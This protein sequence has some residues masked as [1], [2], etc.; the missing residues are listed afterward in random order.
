VADPVLRTEHLVLHPLTC[1]LAR[2]VLDGAG[3]HALA[4]GFPGPDDRSLLD[5]LVLAGAGDDRL[6]ARRP[7]TGSRRH[8]G[9]AAA[10]ARRRPGARLR[11]GPAARGIGTG[12][13]AVAAVAAVL[14]RRSGV[15][16]L[17]AAV[18]PATLPRCACSAA[19]LRRGGRRHAAARAARPRR[20]GLPPLRPRTA[21]RHVC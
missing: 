11:P 12:T 9:A 19:R 7:A 20:T 10:S 1:E 15:R 16:R 5:G 6:L 4:E 8:R 14:E 18:L 3:P 2:A 21:G 13:Q 17:T